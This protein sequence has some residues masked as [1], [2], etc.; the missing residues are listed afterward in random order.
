M[1]SK[2]KLRFNKVNQQ[3]IKE[4]ADDNRTSFAAAVENIQ[5]ILTHRVTESTLSQTAAS[6]LDK[7]M[8]F[9]DNWGAPKYS[10]NHWKGTP[11]SKLTSNCNWEYKKFS[12]QMEAATMNFY[13]SSEDWIAF[14]GYDL[15]PE[16]WGLYPPLNVRFNGLDHTTKGSGINAGRCQIEP[17]DTKDGSRWTIERVG[18][19]KSTGNYDWWQF[20]WD[21]PFQ[22]NEILSKYKDGYFILNHFSGAVDI[23]GETLGFP[24]IHIHHVHVSPGYT[25]HFR[26][27]RLNC[28]LGL[29]DTQCSHAFATVFE[30]HGGI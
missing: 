5:P 1:K 12:E 20:A 30:Q 21:N 22:T 24:A 10:V 4:V 29:D 11:L 7:N 6:K 25:N 13:S 26:A 23:N 27:N 14:K 18:P 28:V 17:Q 8:E 15:V 9:G 16:N 2:P 19:L 3:D